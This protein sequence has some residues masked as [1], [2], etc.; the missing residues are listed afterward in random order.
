MPSPFPGMNP[1][2]E[3]PSLWPGFHSRY[4]TSLGNAINRSAPDKYFADIEQRVFLVKPGDSYQRAIVPDVSI[5]ESANEISANQLTSEGS[6]ATK[7]VT[8]S[9]R[10]QMME[11]E[12]AERFITIRAGAGAGDVDS[13]IVTIIEIL[14]PS[15]KLVG[16]S[17]RTS[18]LAKREEVLKTRTHFIEIDLLRAGDRRPLGPGGYDSDYLVTLS[19]TEERPVAELWPTNLPSPLPTIPIPLLLGDADLV[20]DLQQILHQVYD[21]SGYSRRIRHSDPIPAPP[22]SDQNAAW[23]KQLKEA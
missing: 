8:P 13:E 2:L 21:E 6:I 18:Y 12:I 22:L 5:N 4:I 19:R 10:V 15:N 11:E 14:S 9:I 1:Y 20:M 16:S 3:S 17:G 23:L 7:T